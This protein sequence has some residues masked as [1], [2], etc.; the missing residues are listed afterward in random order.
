M[1]QPG[2]PMNSWLSQ[3]AIG[4][5]RY[6]KGDLEKKNSVRVFAEGFRVLEL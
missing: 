2:N 3:Q 6:V 1:L 4:C 5:A